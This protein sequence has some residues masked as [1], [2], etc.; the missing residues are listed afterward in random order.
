VDEVKKM[1]ENWAKR[2]IK[3]FIGREKWESEI[4]ISKID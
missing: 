2:N 4:V 3:P 1:E